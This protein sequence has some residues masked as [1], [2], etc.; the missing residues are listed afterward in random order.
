MAVAI[1]TRFIGVSLLDGMR[2]TVWTP[3]LQR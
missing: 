1:R 2:R 3:G